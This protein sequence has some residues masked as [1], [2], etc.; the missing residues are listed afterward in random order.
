MNRRKA[1]VDADFATATT[2]FNTAKANYDAQMAK[3]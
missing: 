2:E 1:E 3:V